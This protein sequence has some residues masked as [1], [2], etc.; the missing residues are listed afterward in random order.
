MKLLLPMSSLGWR[1]VKWLQYPG[2]HGLHQGDSVGHHIIPLRV[3][4]GGL[5]AGFPVRHRLVT[6]DMIDSVQLPQL[7]EQSS[8]RHIRP[9]SRPVLDPPGPV[10]APVIHGPRLERVGPYV[11]H[12][13]TLPLVRAR[14][15]W[16]S[17][18][19]CIS[20]DNSATGHQLALY[21][22]IASSTFNYLL[23]VLEIAVPLLGYHC[24]SHHL[25]HTLVL[26]QQGTVAT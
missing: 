1:E 20:C 26:G 22:C 19:R 13:T 17:L 6:P 25:V 12:I 16:E 18:E 10:V 15:E 9:N 2:L 11:I 7:G 8:I 4:P 3:V 24:I 5:P 14:P 23:L 21:F